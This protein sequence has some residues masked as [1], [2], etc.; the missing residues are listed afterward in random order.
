MARQDRRRAREI[1]IKL[2]APP[3]ALA[4]LGEHPSLRAAVAS[5][6]SRRQSASYFDTP[7][8]RLREAG[9]ALRLRRSEGDKAGRQTLKSAGPAAGLFERDEWECAV[10][11]RAPDFDA[12]SATP[13]AALLADPDVRGA[14]APVFSVDVTRAAFSVS[15][16]GL[17]AEIVSDEGEIRAGERV[18]P[19]CEIE[20]E[21]M[22]GKPR[23]LF[24]L[25]RALLETAPLRLAVQSKSERGYALLTGIGAVRGRQTAALAPDMRVGEAFRTIA[26]ACLRQFVLNEAALLA[27]PT[28]GAIHQMRVAIRRLRAAM[29]VFRK[30]IDDKSREGVS[31]GLRGVARSL[32]EARDLD[33][34]IAGEID[35]MR[36]KRPDD[37]DAARLAAHF[38]RQRDA[39]YARVMEAIGSEAHRLA[40]FDALA[41][42]EAGRWRKNAICA[43]PVRDFAARTLARRSAG[44]RKR[45][46]AISSLDVEERHEL[47]LA[48]KKLRY[49]A[50]FFAPLFSEDRE[51]GARATRYAKSL[52][53]LQDRLGELNDAATA[54]SLT[55]RLDRNDEAQM[56]AARMIAEDRVGRAAGSLAAA[57]TA[58]AT[59]AR[60]KPFWE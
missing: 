16:K 44:I 41:F 38:A 8:L 18:D 40:I 31:D 9:F 25:A 50:E 37:P 57:R 29:S 47:R 59:F 10:A 53:A 7:D 60:A 22:R 35:P 21:L 54:I 28:P 49:A 23:R 14:L 11:G 2:T 46:R 15:D 48:V 27:A 39:A 12:L 5:A 1:E 55:G 30:A 24:K 45:A 36:E 52:A 56:R 6:R 42:V 43:A 33:V 58:G 26:R 19:V 51:T 3:G 4:L 34:F 20:L 17:T 13:A 32:S